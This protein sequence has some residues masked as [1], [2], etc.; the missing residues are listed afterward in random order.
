MRF[1]DTQC[2]LD[3]DQRMSA[4]GYPGELVKLVHTIFTGC[5][6]VI[7]IGA[8][9]GHFAIPLAQ[10]GYSITAIEP[11]SA[12]AAIFKEKIH[13]HEFET[14]ITIDQYRWEDWRGQSP[15]KRAREMT[16]ILCAYSIYGITDIQSGIEKMLR[17][18][19]TIVIL[20]GDDT[21]S[22]T[23]S[24]T[25]RQALALTPC[26]RKSSEKIVTAL[27]TLNIA[28]TMKS[29]EM[30]RR[31]MFNDIDAES[32]YFLRHL[33][34]AEQYKTRIK[35]ILRQVCRHDFLHDDSP[36]GPE[37]LTPGDAGSALM[38]TPGAS[39]YFFDNI[40]RDIMF[41]IQE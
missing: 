7:D 9:S 30:E 15:A 17:F 29:I 28:Y 11:S 26:T 8:G 34:L 23:L 41:V 20:I 10:K 21:T 4:E 32:E 16:A 24:G 3:Y 6:N 25:I 39:G 22:N 5:K 13:G 19:R 12:M 2:A 33:G 40:Y 38:N 27:K 35:Q 37:A 14:N 31:T 1:N 36:P 18:S